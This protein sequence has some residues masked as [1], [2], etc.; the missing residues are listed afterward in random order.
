[1]GLFGQGKKK[2]AKEVVKEWQTKLRK[3]QRVLERQIYGIQK[4]E[5]K[6]KQSLKMAA[7]RGETTSCKVLAK[8]IVR[9]RKAVN[10]IRVAQAQM[11][12]VEYNM[13]NQLA[14]VRVSGSLQ[15][16]TEVMQ[17]MQK[18]VN[19][20]E[21]AKTMRDMSKEMMKM[22]IIEEML[23]E[24]LDDMDDQEELEDEVQEEVD[25]V[26]FEITAGKIGEAPDAVKDSL[27][28]IVPEPEPEGAVGGQEADVTDMQARLEAL[29]S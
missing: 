20:G 4:E 1:M 16:S 28:V 25:K 29:R 17:A 22:G 27:P 23:E 2:D 12:S 18:L 26:I 11:K 10:K 8:E 21:V 24:T 5:G 14:T 9:S 6:A 15:K 3:E 7:K 13:A 19:I